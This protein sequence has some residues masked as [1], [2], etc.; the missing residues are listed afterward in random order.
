MIPGKRGA[1]CCDWI[2]NLA[3]VQVRV[4]GAQFKCICNLLS[5]L[6]VNSIL[7]TGWFWYSWWPCA[8]S[9]PGR[10]DSSSSRNIIDTNWDWISNVMATYFTFTFR[11]RERERE[12][13]RGNKSNTGRAVLGLGKIGFGVDG[14]RRECSGHWTILM[15]TDTEDRDGVGLPQYL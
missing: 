5:T 6:S 12:G 1:A 3:L 14:V 4:S 13:W 7:V 2:T 11:L 9:Q 8:L 15:S 10:L